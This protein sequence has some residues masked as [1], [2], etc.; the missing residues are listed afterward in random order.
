MLK[1]ARWSTTHRKYV[2]LGWIVL[3]FGVNALAQCARR[4]ARS[5]GAAEG[6]EG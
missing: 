6:A 1:L 2:L 3:L 5:G 4:G